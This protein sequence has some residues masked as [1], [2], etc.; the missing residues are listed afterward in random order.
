MTEPPQN[1]ISM[2]DFA[3][4]MASVNAQKER[5]EADLLSR[6]SAIWSQNQKLDLETLRELSY[7]KNGL[8]IIKAHPLWPVEDSRKDIDLAF[9]ILSRSRDNTLRSYGEFHALIMH[10]QFNETKRLSNDLTNSVFQFSFAAS[11]LVQAY[12]RF[13]SVGSNYADKLKSARAAIFSNVGLQ[14]FVQEVRNCYGHQKFLIAEPRGSVRYGETKEVESSVEFDRDKLL[15]MRDAWNK[16][17]WQFIQNNERL[18][19]MAIITEYHDMAEKF[20]NRYTSACGLIEDI[21]FQEINRCREAIDI[22]RAVF[23]LG[24]LMQ[25]AKQ[26]GINPYGHIRRYFTPEELQ[27]IYCFEHRSKAQVDYMLLLRDPLG[28]TDES[29]RRSLYDLFDCLDE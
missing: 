21:G 4:I 19:I 24:M 1:T 20:Y 11:A 29:F 18:D 26:N 16:E 12:R 5:A 17:A 25:N 6:C 27:R 3:A 23:S 10:G 22:T 28:L 7:S 13:E 14:K 15:Q 2:N 8:S 9:D